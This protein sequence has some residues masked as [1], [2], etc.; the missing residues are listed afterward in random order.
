MPDQ[1]A[2]YRFQ[3]EAELAQIMARIGGHYRRKLIALAGDP[4]NVDRIPD[5]LWDEMRAEIRKQTAQTLLAA[6]LIAQDDMLRSPAFDFEAEG[7]GVATAR[8]TLTRGRT[9]E[10]YRAGQRW[11]TQRVDDFAKQWAQTSRDRFEDILR[12]SQR[13]ADLIEP[14]VDL[15][16]VVRAESAGI[17]EITGAITNGEQAAADNIEK[18]RGVKLAAYWQTELDDRV[19]TICRPLNE[20]PASEW[21]SRFGSGPPAHPR[22]RCYLEWRPAAA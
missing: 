8:R 11:V 20:Q 21:E 16:G 2:Y 22:C 17:T 12:T 14:T 10:D 1:S 9:L 19:C 15:F 5:S 6:F 18:N 4:P 7:G 3:Q 13:Q